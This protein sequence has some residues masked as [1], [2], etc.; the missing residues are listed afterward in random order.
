MSIS[1]NIILGVAK[2]NRPREE[3]FAT[4]VALGLTED[5]A[6]AALTP[7]KQERPA[8]ASEPKERRTTAQG[9][10]IGTRAKGDLVKGALAYI[11]LHPQASKFA[12]LKHG[13][14]EAYKGI[15]TKVDAKK[16]SLPTTF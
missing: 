15:T 12:A 14:P 3:K 7:A 8:K 4:L 10:L 6:T 13:N 11:S 2:S 1:Q 9:R 16:A 5:E